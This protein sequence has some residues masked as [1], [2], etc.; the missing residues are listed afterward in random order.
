VRFFYLPSQH[1]HIPRLP[2]GVV[3]LLRSRFLSRTTRSRIKLHGVCLPYLNWAAWECVS[4]WP[5]AIG[6]GMRQVN[7]ATWGVCTVL[8]LGCMGFVH[9]TRIGLHEVCLPYCNWAT[10]SVFTIL[11][12]G[13]TKCVY[14]TAIGLHEVCLPYSNWATWGASTVLKLGMGCVNKWPSGIFRGMRPAKWATW[15]VSTVC[16]LGYMRC[17]Y[18]TRFESQMIRCLA[19]ADSN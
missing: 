19:L 10:R 15:G 4:K 6:R 1:D 12:L 13:Y 7:L 16:E 2:A 18:C 9:R 8:E 3:D 11:Q 14:H 17:V 5:S